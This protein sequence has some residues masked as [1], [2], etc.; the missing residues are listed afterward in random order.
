MGEM[1]TLEVG[2]DPDW[3]VPPVGECVREGDGEAG[4]MR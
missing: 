3:W 1:G 2:D 4:R